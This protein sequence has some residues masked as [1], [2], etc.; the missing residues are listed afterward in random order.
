MAQTKIIIAAAVGAVMFLVTASYFLLTHERGY[1]PRFDVS[2]AE[3]AFSGAHPVVLFDEGHGNAGLSRQAYRPFVRLLRNDGYEVR[4][5]QDQLTAQTLAGVSVLVIAQA[6]GAGDAPAFT[7]AE[8]SAVAEWVLLGGALLLV[9]D[10][11]PFA[12]A[13]AP[14]ADRF[15]VEMHGAETRDQAHADPAI[16]ATDIVF[17]GALLGEHP[18]LAGRTPRERVARVGVFSGVSLRGPADSR[19]LLRL[20]DSAQDR[21][22]GASAADAQTSA[23]G[24][25]Q[26]VAVGFARGRVVV[27]GDADMLR[28]YFD[29]AGEPIGMNRPGLDNRQFALNILHWLSRLI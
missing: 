25:A 17:S 19:P 10:P 7:E 24:R 28:A 14:L 26:G 5:S 16:R 12:A 20:A 22:L 1:D 6:R 11:G 2:V 27:L 9:S 23:A 4:V 15:G 29:N 13:V 21:P 8:A 3:P 18:I